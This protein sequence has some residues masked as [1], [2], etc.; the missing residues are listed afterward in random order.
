M[1]LNLL[2]NFALISSF[3][4]LFYHLRNVYSQSDEKENLYSDFEI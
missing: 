3:H 4:E 1:S 2:K